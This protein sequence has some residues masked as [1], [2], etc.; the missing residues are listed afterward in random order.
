MN[1]YPLSLRLMIG[2][3]IL[4]ALGVLVFVLKGVEI[5]LAISVVGII[6]LFVGFIWRL[7]KKN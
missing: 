5:V 1:L 2:G 3:I 7:K 6:L 4:I